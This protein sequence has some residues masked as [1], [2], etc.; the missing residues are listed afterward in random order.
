[1]DYPIETRRHSAA[2]VMAA[3][4]KRLF[5]QTKFGVGPAIDNGFY[6]D[7]DIG[8]P[9]TPEDLKAIDKEMYKD[10]NKKTGF[11]R[12]EMSIDEGIKLFESL[13]Q[14]Y[15]VELLNDI[16]TKGTTKLNAEEAG[17]V[18]AGS[19]TIS[20]YRTGDFVDLC[21][22]PHVAHAS[23]IGVFKLYR[24]AGVYWRGKE[25]NPQLQRVYGLC[26]ATEAELDAYEKM[27]VEAEKRDHKKLGRELGLFSFSELVGS[28]LPLW[29]PKGTVLR[30]LLDEYVWE[31]RRAK[32]FMKVAIP[33]ITKKDLYVTS[34]HWAKFKDELFK[35]VTREKH[36]Y[37]LKPMNCPHHTQIFDSEMRSYRDMP[38][39][40]AETTMV[41]R[42]EQSGELSGLSRVLCITQ[43][44]AHVFCRKS[45]I[46]QEYFALWDIIDAFYSTFGFE[47]SLRL[48]THDP[49]HF[50]KYLGT[51]EIWQDAEGQL[52]GLVAKRGATY[53]EGK[54]EAAMYGPK[55]DFMGKDALG[56]MHQVATIQLDFNMPTN[57]GLNCVNEKGEKESIVMI[58]CAVMGSIERFLSVLIEHYAGAFPLWLSP[59]Q[60]A[61]LPVA[62]R[63]N[64]FAHKL[65]QELRDAGIR[66][67]VDDAAES[68]GKKIRNSEKAKMPLALVV[69]DKEMES[70]DLTIRRR[71][72]E[73]Q[74]VMAK[75]DFI[76]MVAGKIKDRK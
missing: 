10:V 7:I 65:A 58:H 26:F 55:L 44:D 19:S 54:G 49:D 12:E 27:L 56:R 76:A 42:D 75:A 70:G 21:R 8:R 38:Q 15:K 48:S 39:R 1:M 34:G 18:E 30:T 23:E 52:K 71:G 67:E 3:A 29:S 72:V 37:A 51:P 40:Y 60:V 14:D 36:E 64:E 74:D 43:D 22:G 17:D 61:V 50:E 25:T 32:G 45:Q 63:H 41:Y 69:G 68:V 46:E 47:L 33:H 13:G 16:K 59:V 62:D 24:M 9:L 35:I 5:P 66:V 28:G 57:F 73:E 4:V 31:L 2:H 6:Y 53:V 11:V 20:V